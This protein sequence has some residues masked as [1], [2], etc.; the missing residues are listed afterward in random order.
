MLKKRTKRYIRVISLTL[1]LL[2]SFQSMSAVAESAAITNS[3][4]QW[5]IEDSLT[6]TEPSDTLFNKYLD[7]NFEKNTAEIITYNESGE[8][9]YS[10]SLSGSVG[11]A[12]SSLDLCFWHNTQDLGNAA[13]DS[14]I[15]DGLETLSCNTAG[16]NFMN[17][18]Y[19][20]GIGWSL[21]LPQIEYIN[22]NVAYY[23]NGD[24]KAY[25]ICKISPEDETEEETYT[26]SGFPYDYTIEKNITYESEEDTEGTLVGFIG[27]DR[28]GNETY[29]NRDGRFISSI[30]KDGDILKTVTYDENKLIATYTEEDYSISF[31][32][33]TIE[34]TTEVALQMTSSYEETN[35][36]GETSTVTENKVIY[37]L[38]VTDQRLVSVHEGEKDAEPV[39]TTETD[40]ENGVTL[41]TTD[42]DENYL[43][44]E[45]TD[46]P[47]AIILNSESDSVESSL[48]G[49]DVTVI[50][51]VTVYS[52]SS[53][54]E[55]YTA[56]DKTNETAVTF[57]NT[58]N[59]TAANDISTSSEIYLFTYSKG[60]KSIGAQSSVIMPRLSKM[61]I[62]D[63][64]SVTGEETET[65]NIEIE[66][67]YYNNGKVSD[68]D[69]YRNDRASEKI[70]YL[71]SVDE[72]ENSTVTATY[73]VDLGNCKYI[74]FDSMYY[75]YDAPIEWEE[76]GYI[77]TRNPKGEIVGYQ[78]AEGP[79]YNYEY[80]ELGEVTK[81]TFDNYIIN[82]NDSGQMTNFVLKGTETEEEVPLTQYTY[83]STDLSADL[84]TAITYANS[85][86][87]YNSYDQNGNITSI[88]SGNELRY[89]FTYD[90]ENNV[91][92][93][94][95]ILGNRQTEYVDTVIEEEF[96]E[97]ENTTTEN[98]IVAD[99]T[100]NTTEENVSDTTEQ[101]TEDTVLT[102]RT[103]KVYD[104]SNETP[105]L[106]YSY[107]VDGD[108]K[109][110]TLD[111]VSLDISTDTED[112]LDESEK[113]T[114]IKTTSTLTAP[115]S[116]YTNENITTP[117][118]TLT[119]TSVKKGDTIIY[120]K[121]ME[122][123]SKTRVTKEYY[124]VNDQV[125]T[126]YAYEDNNISTITEQYRDRRYVYDMHGQITNVYDSLLGSGSKRYTYDSRGN[127]TT[128]ESYRYLT[129]VSYGD[130]YYTDT[131]S[132]NNP[133]WKDLLTAHN[134]KEITYDASGNPLT[135]NGY[136]YTWDMG[137]RLTSI[138]NGTNNYTYTYDENGLR[139]SKTVNGETTRFIYDNNILKSQ[140]TD[141][142]SMLFWYDENN[143]PVG[144]VYTDKTAEIQ[145]PETFIYKKNVFG[146][147]IGVYN[148]E[149]S[150]IAQYWYDEWGNWVDAVWDS[151]EE[152][153]TFILN[154]NPLLYRGYYFDNET[155][156][157]YLQSRYYNP[158]WCRFINAD[159]VE[160]IGVSDKPVSVNPFAYCVNNPTMRVDRTG[161]AVETLFDIVSI[162]WSLWD[163]I[164]APSWAN[165]GYLLWDLVSLIPYIPGSYVGKGG[166]LCIE[167]ASKI[168]DFARGSEFLTGSYKKLK[169]LYKGVKNI[170]IH[171]LV[172]KRFKKLFKGI[173]V[174]DYL[175]IPLEKELHKV[176]T[177]RW[178]K[179]LPYGM[180][181]KKI[182]KKQMEKAIKEVYKDMPQLLEET[183]KW[184]KRNWKK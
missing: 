92:S 55:N 72:A 86:S 85:Q 45:Y 129:N 124:G 46:I 184:F 31:I 112:I 22:Q 109:N 133:N 71:Y 48:S 149:G 59:E 62:T 30:D 25:R 20:L 99:G 147:I 182:T 6:A 178:R 158:R 154:N 157:Y 91:T 168:S 156:Y 21:S 137:R 174:K 57:A 102:K 3:T 17:S 54:V 101:E 119:S 146:D 79:H 35:E 64:S 43:L 18:V 63:T 89:T 132:Y 144:F 42:T 114:S 173:D 66:L 97:T 56:I 26:L 74:P 27:T 77:T 165:A 177:K 68:Y 162:V 5:L 96:T 106:M 171:H 1:A 136:T 73:T 105:V 49:M 103:A 28:Y 160:Y 164:T 14:T 12:T 70:N 88:S 120:S 167:V 29:F 113:V 4:Y 172:E 81:I 7:K 32:R 11:D 145:T 2:L 38:T 161:Y 10:Y 75:Y 95:D 108:T 117:H 76:A 143:S 134:G 181:Y 8:V 34:D 24:G 175:S 135:Y 118:G 169:K 69:F 122:Y 33:T 78:Y 131:F 110:I 60:F 15:L 140:Y 152:K 180:N 127:V 40:E 65:N 80:N 83:T 107:D 128:R 87:V 61:V 163:L 47:S 123:D 9:D 98:G 53:T 93:V 138:S 100:E 41:T 155:R 139:T 90:E 39:I 179:I 166:K 126:A 13:Y 153:Y 141:N 104:I 23:H 44:Y 116:T 142:Y 151:S 52:S 159:A 94:T 121:S 37:T 170:E 176:I 16:I 58:K 111:A 51:K 125:G 50:S 19:G 36:S 130:L 115:D 183:L 67:T 82:Y 148:F 150:L 84:L